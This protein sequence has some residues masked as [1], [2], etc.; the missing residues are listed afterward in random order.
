MK[1]I[2]FMATGSLLLAACTSTADISASPAYR[3]Q[4]EKIRQ[5]CAHYYSGQ[6]MATEGKIANCI[7]ARK[8]G[9]R[10]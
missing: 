4:L 2:L 7:N 10:L 6:D 8:A 1:N 5:D 9:I 3:A